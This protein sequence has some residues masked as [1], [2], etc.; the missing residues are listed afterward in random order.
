MEPKEQAPKCLACFSL[1][2]MSSLLLPVILNRAKAEGI[3]GYLGG[4]N[5]WMVLL[6]DEVGLIGSQLKGD[7]LSHRLLRSLD[8][9]LKGGLSKETILEIA[10]GGILA[11]P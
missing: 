11:R 10:W 1:K 5:K 9:R 6:T 7:R 3:Y 2:V 8:S 4:H